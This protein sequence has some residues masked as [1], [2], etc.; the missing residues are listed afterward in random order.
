MKLEVKHEGEKFIGMM[1]GK[2]D[3]ACAEQCGKDMQ[4]LLDNADK[5]L[6][7]DCT[8]LEYISSSG[9]RLLLVL[10]KK[11]EAM[12]GSLVIEHLCDGVRSVFTL[13]GFFKL[14]DIR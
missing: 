3:T 2:L 14:F 1:T 8:N 4:P 7:L 10:R 9:L 5:E 6:V 12:G 11:V 13:T